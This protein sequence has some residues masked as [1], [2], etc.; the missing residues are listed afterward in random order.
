MREMGSTYSK[1]V[2]KFLQCDFSSGDD[3]N[4]PDLQVVFHRDGVCEQE[5][6]GERL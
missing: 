2:K 3:F 5:R 4:D 1:I 6:L